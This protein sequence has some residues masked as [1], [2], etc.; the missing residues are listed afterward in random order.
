M[1][2]EEKTLELDEETPEKSDQS[3]GKSEQASEKSAGTRGILL[4]A[5]FTLLGGIIGVLVT[6]G[7]NLAIEKQKSDAELS[8]ER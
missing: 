8:L 6:G 4:S 2:D 3:P 7:F 5:A 1:Q